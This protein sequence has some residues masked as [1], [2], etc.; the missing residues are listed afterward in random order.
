M[1]WSWNNNNKK[2]AL[3]VLHCWSYKYCGLSATASNYSITV[4]RSAWKVTDHVDACVVWF[5]EVLTIKKHAW[6]IINTQHWEIVVHILLHW[7]TSCRTM[8]TPLLLAASSGA[9]STLQCLIELGA[10]VL[11]SDQLGNNVIHLAALRC[12]ANVLEFFSAWQQ[13][14]VDVWLLLVG[15]SSSTR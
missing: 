14:Q 11:R 1:I 8:S 9:L 5:S 4:F 2:T 13:P 12:H 6:Y 7:I 15:R 3:E 10:D